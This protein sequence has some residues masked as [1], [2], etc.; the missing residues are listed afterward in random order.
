MTR[1]IKLT[2]EQEREIL[3]PAN[4]PDGCGITREGKLDIGREQIANERKQV[5]E[6]YQQ[7]SLEKLQDRMRALEKEVRALPDLMAQATAEALKQGT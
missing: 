3:D 1:E 5:R 6:G 7:R 2:R 4:W